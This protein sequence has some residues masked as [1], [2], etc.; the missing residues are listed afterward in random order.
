MTE[1]QWNPRTLEEDCRLLKGFF[2]ENGASTKKEPSGFLTHRFLV[3]GGCF[4]SDT[5]WDWDS[6]LS[7]V[8]L[9]QV[10]LD[11]QREGEFFDYQAGC[12]QNFFDMQRPDGSIPICATSQGIMSDDGLSFEGRNPHKPV[13]LQHAAFLVQHYGRIDWLRPLA[14]QFQPYLKAFLAEHIHEKT[15]LAYWQNDFAVGVD[16]DP[17]VFY[18]PEKS[19]GSIYLNSLL[20]KEMK[21]CAFLLERCGDNPGAAFW[22][23]QADRLRM[24]V[25][26]HCWDE[27]DGTYYSVDFNLLP[28]C[29]E[30]WLHQGAPRHWDCLLMRIDNW[31]SFLPLWAGIPDRQQAQRMVFRAC[32]PETFSCRG[33]IRTLSRLEKMYSLHATNNPSNW[34]GP[35]WGISNYLVFRGLVRYGFY[36]EAR[37]LAE[38]TI[39]LFAED[40]GKEGALHEY[41]HPDTGEGM[42]TPGFLNW[43]GL[44]LQMIAWLE[45]RKTAWEF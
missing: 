22:R 6:W 32:D 14:A 17:S 34:L 42:M 1:P 41:Y 23:A 4:Y 30:H 15:G 9:G 20:H 21:A 28:I 7:G 26:R 45:G 35:V 27:R 8:M 18:R 33:G 2:Q 43:N 31:S 44:V 5:L 29:P 11:G 12:I 10:E 25:N 38:K 16:N 39:R 37:E 36:T 3:P 40:L 19:C 24:A 13:L